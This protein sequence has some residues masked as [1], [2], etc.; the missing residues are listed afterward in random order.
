[1]PAILLSSPIFRHLEDGFVIFLTKE[2]VGNLSKG[3]IKTYVN[4]PLPVFTD[5]LWKTLVDNSVENVEKLEFSTDILRF[6]PR[7]TPFKPV[8]R[9][10]KIFYFPETSQIM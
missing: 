7:L 2:K 10:C 1:L 5:P 9:S 8:S 3:V 4:Q 6:W